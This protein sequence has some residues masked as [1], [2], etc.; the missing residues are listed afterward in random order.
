L[1]GGEAIEAYLDVPKTSPLAESAEIQAA[2]EYDG[3]DQNG[4]G[5]DLMKQVVAA[6]P[7]IHGGFDWETNTDAAQGFPF[8]HG[9]GNL[10]KQ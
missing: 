9:V 1:R 8:A 4:K 7:A 10:I 6:N 3:L 5:L 2:I